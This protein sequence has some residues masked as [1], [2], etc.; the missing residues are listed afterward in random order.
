LILEICEKHFF[1]SFK[2]STCSSFFLCNLLL[3]Q[4][5]QAYVKSI[6]CLK[7]EDAFSMARSKVLPW[8]SWLTVCVHP[9]HLLPGWNHTA[10]LRP[11]L[12]RT[13]GSILWT[14]FC[15]GSPLRD[16]E[17]LT[18]SSNHINFHASE[19]FSAFGFNSNQRHF[20]E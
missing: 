17:D 19:S 16:Y 4:V 15:Q 14:A 20:C 6:A 3:F 7:W 10:L 11:D 2:F 5:H 1:L 18:P 13:L 9:W 8:I 12:W